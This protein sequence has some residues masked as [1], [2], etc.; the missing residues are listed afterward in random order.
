MSKDTIKNG[1]FLI[2]EYQKK[3]IVVKYQ[4]KSK[5]WENEDVYSDEKLYDNRFKTKRTFTQL[6]GFKRLIIRYKILNTT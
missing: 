4:A 1:L 5:K 3:R 2:F 6:H